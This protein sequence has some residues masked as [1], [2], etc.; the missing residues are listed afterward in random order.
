MN[1][2]IFSLLSLSSYLVTVSAFLGVSYFVSSQPSAVSRQPSA[3]SNQWSVLSGQPLAFGT[4]SS[5][6]VALIAVR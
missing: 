1:L 4:S 2:L 3:V 5:V 6:R